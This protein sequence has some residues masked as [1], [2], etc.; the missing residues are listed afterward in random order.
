MISLGAGRTISCSASASCA[1][2]FRLKA[3]TRVTAS[4]TARE[5]WKLTGWTGCRA[6]ASTCA[7]TIIRPLRLQAVFVAPGTRTNPI[8]LGT[9]ETLSPGWQVRV[10]SAQLQP[11]NYLQILV[12]VDVVGGSSALNLDSL[13]LDMYA[14]GASTASRTYD[15]QG[16]SCRTNTAT[17]TL[18]SLGK[19]GPL[20]FFYVLNGQ[21]VTGY[22][23]FQVALADADSLMLAVEPG[24]SVNP[25]P[26]NSTVDSKAV[27]FALH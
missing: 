6:G 1:R 20:G 15:Q 12:T 26:P 10:N 11:Q 16:S 18:A 19:E 27:W 13:L 3:G 2:T 25:P 24:V 8:P 9:T 5:G 7:L 21:P 23:C 22:V 4:A 17:P 14:S